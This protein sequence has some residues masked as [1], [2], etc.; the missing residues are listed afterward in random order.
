MRPRIPYLVAADILGHVVES[1]NYPQAEFLP[2]LVLCNSNILNVS[3]NAE[4]V[5]AVIMLVSF[6]IQSSGTC[7]AAVQVGHYP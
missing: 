6:S 4:I 3:Y 7:V 1:L 2:L 5:Y